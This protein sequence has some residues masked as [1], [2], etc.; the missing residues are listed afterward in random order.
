MILK[1]EMTEE[2]KNEINSLINSYY[3]LMEASDMLLRRAEM[4]F[5]NFNQGLKGPVKVR[6][7]R[8]M[9]HIAALKRE[10]DTFFNDYNCFGK[11]ERYI[12]KY[13]M[14]RDCASYLAR[15][16]LLIG[17]RSCRDDEK[18][19]RQRIWDYIYY[20][21]EQ[22]LIKDKALDYLKLR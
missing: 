14:M 19:V 2:E 22:G 12:A 10:Q 21:P 1:R 20:M 9:S 3:V 5:A 15:L 8:M 18:A 6:H 11:D 17:D 16:T 13:D 7:N 4:L